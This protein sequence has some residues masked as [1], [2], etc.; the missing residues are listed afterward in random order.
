M[1]NRVI[2]IGRAVATPEL[3][4]TPNGKAVCRLSLAVNRRYRNADGDRQVDFINL[5]LWG[6]LAENLVSYGNKGS[7]L[8]V[9]GE[10]RTRKYDK[11]GQTVYFTEVLGQ[12]FQ[13]LESKAQRAM[14]ANHFNPDLADLEVEEAELPF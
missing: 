12:S 8:S 5:V 4:R 1:Y 11:D 2:L 6:K 9:E 10:L 13:L 7:L 3:I 14:R